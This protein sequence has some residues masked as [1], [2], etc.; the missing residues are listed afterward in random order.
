MMNQPLLLLLLILSVVTGQEG[1]SSCGSAA[2]LSAAEIAGRIIGAL[3]LLLLAALFSGL[4]LGVLG[5]DVNDLEIM[6]T[7]GTSEQQRF[8]ALIQPVRAQGNLLLCTLVLGNVAVTSLESILLADLTSGLVGF[9]LTTFLVVIFGEIIP[10]AICARYALSIGAR[11]VPIVK[12]LL[13][14]FYPATKP[15]SMLLD[16]FLGEEIG[17]TYTRAEFMKLVQMHVAAEK[18]HSSEANIISG[19]L[20]YRSKA[21]KE[22]MTPVVDMFAV[23][24]R[25]VSL[26]RVSP[27][28]RLTRFPHPYPGL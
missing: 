11:A 17:T 13:F 6:R 12:V 27:E 20:A 2:T 10:Q 8:A 4:T 26:L 7:A 21:V 1:S 22:I 18:L 5:L 23:K 25:D 9:L 19:A 16:Y 14:L 3:V 24:V 15:L 28:R